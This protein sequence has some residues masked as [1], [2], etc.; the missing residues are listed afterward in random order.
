MNLRRRQTQ[1]ILLVQLLLTKMALSLAFY[2]V[3]ILLHPMELRLEKM[4]ELR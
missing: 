1:E 4:K 3:Q 2:L